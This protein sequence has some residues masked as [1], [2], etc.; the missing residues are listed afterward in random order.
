MKRKL[1]AL[2]GLILVG[3][4]V[5]APSSSAAADI[6]P[7]VTCGSGMVCIYPQTEFRG[8]PYVRRATNSSTSLVSNPIDDNTF[9][10]VNNGASPRTARIYRGSN[11]TGSWTCIRPGTSIPDLRGHEVGRYGS[12][13]RLNN[14]TC[15]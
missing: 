2:L 10:V 9:S 15:G 4:F 3:V 8:V 1:S 5:P 11:Y 6:A 13:L 12:S 14:D 7:M